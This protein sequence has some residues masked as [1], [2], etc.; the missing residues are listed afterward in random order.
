MSRFTARALIPSRVR[1]RIGPLLFSQAVF[2]RACRALGPV[3][4]G[5]L[6]AWFARPPARSGPGP[7]YLF[8]ARDVA[9]KDIEQ[10]RLH[11]RG[12]W[13]SFSQSLLF[14]AQLAWLPS[15]FFAQLEFQE[16]LRSDPTIRSEP[17]LR[18]A[19][20]LMCALRTRYGIDA[21]LSSNVDYAQD[22][23]VRQACRQLGIPFVVLLK[24]HVNTAYGERVWSEEYMRT[25]Y[26]YEGDAVAVFGPRTR[27]ILIAHDVCAPDVIHVTGP[28][29]FDAWATAPQPATVDT[30]VLCA[31][32]HPGQEGAAA[33]PEVLRAFV[34]LVPT[35]PDLVFVVKCR[36]HYEVDRVVGMLGEVVPHGLTVTHEVP[37][38]SLLSRAVLVA[39]FGSLA[40]VE[41]LYSPAEVVSIRFGGCTDDEDVQF[42]ER[43]SEVARIVRFAH[44]AP[45][46]GAMVRTVA[47]A[48]VHPEHDDRIALLH[49]FFCAP[50]PSHSAA[51]DVALES[52]VLG[53]SRRS[54]APQAT[55][56]SALKS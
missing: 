13:I 40:L 4:A 37:M 53:L 20:A 22:E 30:V 9:Y 29:R 55:G 54:P 41:A 23:F 17:S 1:H 33:F 24:E 5:R 35:R 3:L 15:D 50:Q 31:F 42:D 38:S 21:V 18:F 10:L 7:T 12:T 28:P 14:Q 19:L 16:R 6:C 11:S 36:D 56:A 48:P 32:S 44:S 43:E 49:R 47:A 26:R 45:G 25:G 52:S 2:S 51:L 46:L 8:I 27:E 34:A 39:G